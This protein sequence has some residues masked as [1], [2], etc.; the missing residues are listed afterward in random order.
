VKRQTKNGL[1]PSGV[2]GDY[3]QLKV[4]DIL[5]REVATLVNEK[6]KPGYYEVEFNS[7]SGSV[8]NLSTGIYFY[9]LT[10]GNFIET[11]KMLLIK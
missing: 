1:I 8:R 4:Y 10:A 3:V 9:Q 5:G 6:Q 7:F 11:K 2:E